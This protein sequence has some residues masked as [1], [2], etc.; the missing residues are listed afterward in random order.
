MPDAGYR[1]DEAHAV[2]PGQHFL[3]FAR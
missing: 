2:V 1:L 3:I